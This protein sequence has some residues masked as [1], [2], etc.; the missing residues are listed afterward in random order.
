ME[1]DD[2]VL[3]RLA[4][5]YVWWEPPHR[6]LLRRSNFLCQVLQLGIAEDVRT[7]RRMFGDDVL[8]EALRSAPPGVFDARS[9][10]YWHLVLFGQAPPPLPARP[11]PS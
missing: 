2:D 8:R 4:G 10:N 9:W 5:R 3:R 11:L 6:A 7:V 1:S